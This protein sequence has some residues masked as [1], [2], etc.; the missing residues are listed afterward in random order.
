METTFSISKHPKIAGFTRKVCVVGPFV[1]FQKKTIVCPCDIQH[2]V[3]G[4]LSENYIPTQRIALMTSNDKFVDA[5]GQRVELIEETYIDEQ[6]Q[7]QTR[8]IAPEN[9]VPEF[10]FLF[11]YVSQTQGLSLGDTILEVLGFMIARNDQLGNFNDL[12][13]FNS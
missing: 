1:D 11:N 10:D 2:F 6:N 12:S 5:T 7:E 4:V 8:M 3:G 13:N 9:S